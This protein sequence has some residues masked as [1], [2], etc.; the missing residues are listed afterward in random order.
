ML[1]RLLSNLPLNLFQLIYT[2]ELIL[3][4]RLIIEHEHLFVH[5]QVLASLPLGRSYTL[6][7]GTELVLE[8]LDLLAVPSGDILGLLGRQ[9]P[10]HAS[11]HQ[12][13]DAFLH[14]HLFEVLK[15]ILKD[16]ALLVKFL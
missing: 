6:L 2:R 5:V 15:V 4:A 14:S 1:L 12:P 7:V 10:R 9:P 8:F 3:K 16:F 13:R 11:G